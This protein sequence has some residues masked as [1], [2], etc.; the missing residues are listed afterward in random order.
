[1][2]KRLLITFA[3]VAL[4]GFGLAACGSD[5]SSSSSTTTSSETSASTT[6]ADTSAAAS[7]GTLK[8]AADPSGALAFTETKL[9]APA[10]SDTV[11][12]ENASS[13]GHN[14]EIEDSSGEDVAGTDTITDGKT[15]TTADLQPG[16]YT[17]YCSVPGHREAG[18]EGTIT[19]K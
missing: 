16:T 17:F 8:I 7:G 5:D 12:F 2:P 3:L 18:M 4:A 10:G 13:T 9:T 6:A 15:S 11:D 14:V 19:V 1:M